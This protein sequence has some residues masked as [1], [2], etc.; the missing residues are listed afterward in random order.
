[1]QGKSAKGDSL[2]F[3]LAVV[4][5]LFHGQSLPQLGNERHAGPWILI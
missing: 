3:F 2:Q 1:M 5:V 4:P